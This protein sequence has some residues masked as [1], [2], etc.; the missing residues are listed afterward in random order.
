VTVPEPLPEG[1]VDARPIE[2]AK[3]EQIDTLRKETLEQSL[4]NSP[5]KKAS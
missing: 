3:N 1:R 2:K 4:L 5:L